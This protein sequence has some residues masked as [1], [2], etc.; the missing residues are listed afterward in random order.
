MI[1]AVQNL[2]NMQDGGGK[3]ARFTI[4]CEFDISLGLVL[5]EESHGA[6]DK[7][8]TLGLPS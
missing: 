4:Y 2:I 6:D 5:L 7:Q 1:L 3:L 8:G